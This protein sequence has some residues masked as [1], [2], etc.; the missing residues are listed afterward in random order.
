LPM[1][2]FQSPTCSG[3][4]SHASWTQILLFAALAAWLG[5]ASPPAAEE[6]PETAAQPEE[7]TEAAQVVV[8]GSRIPR[9]GPADEAKT[10]SP[11]R[12][13]TR[14]ELRQHGGASLED[15]LRRVSPTIQVH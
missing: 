12:V 11:R 1:A 7:T 15:S 5:C 2:R 3:T 10:V 13:V 4:R 14:E 6:A 8:T 9:D